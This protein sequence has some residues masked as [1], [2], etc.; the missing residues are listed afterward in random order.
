MLDGFGSYGDSDGDSDGD[1]TLDERAC[2]GSLA[3]RIDEV[4]QILNHFNCYQ[5]S[6]Q[7]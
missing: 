4:S 6:T 5:R 2:K 1:H 3:R 7:T